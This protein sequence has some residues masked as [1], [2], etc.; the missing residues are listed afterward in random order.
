MILMVVNGRR[1]LKRRPHSNSTK[2]QASRR[3]AGWTRDWHRDPMFVP[4][5]PVLV[6]LPMNE[7]SWDDPGRF[8]EIKKKRPW[9]IPLQ[10]VLTPSLRGECG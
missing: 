7:L 1:A 6:H 3:A 2:L 10:A 9:Q 4:C 5:R 8:Q